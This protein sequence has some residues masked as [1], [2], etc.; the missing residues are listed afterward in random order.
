MW[1]WI[2]TVLGASISIPFRFH[3]I[4]TVLKI[5]WS[6]L[7]LFGAYLWYLQNVDWTYKWLKIIAIC[8]LMLLSLLVHELGHAITF[9]YAYDIE[10]TQVLLMALGGATVPTVEP[11]KKGSE[12]VTAVVGPAMNLILAGLLAILYILITDVTAKFFVSLLYTLFFLFN[13]QS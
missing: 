13:L 10:V 11:T 2:S 9:I 4:R 5:H 12:A 1:Y 7:L 3:K 8:F 6:V